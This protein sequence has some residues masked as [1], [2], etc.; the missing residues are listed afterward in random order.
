MSTLYQSAKEID[1]AVMRLLSDKAVAEAAYRPV[2]NSRPATAVVAEANAIRQDIVDFLISAAGVR[3]KPFIETFTS[4]NQRLM[5]TYCSPLDFILADDPQQTV[6]TV[7][8]FGAS[9]RNVINAVS[10]RNYPEA[11]RGLVAICSFAYLA[12]AFGLYAI[13]Y[14]PSIDGPGMLEASYT[15]RCRAY[16]LRNAV[17]AQS[18]VD[19][20][21][22]EIL[23]AVLRM[24][25]APRVDLA[26]VERIKAIA[27]QA[28]L[29]T[30]TFWI[31]SCRILTMVRSKDLK[32]TQ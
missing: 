8:P 23:D 17:W 27:E 25:A 2:P 15:H 21:G 5:E 19:P 10:E 31:Q 4:P 20:E 13:P 22:G 11:D 24:Y 29:A 26:R 18:E 14:R 1:Q 32:V 28:N 16:Y 6:R 9:A 12:G 3:F 30:E 7:M